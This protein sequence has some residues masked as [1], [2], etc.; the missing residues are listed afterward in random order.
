M[1]AQAIDQHQCRRQ[2]QHDPVAGTFRSHDG[3]RQS[4]AQFTELYT[5]VFASRVCR[6]LLASQKVSEQSC[7]HQPF[8]EYDIQAN[9]MSDEDHQTSEQDSK[10]R[11]LLLKQSPPAAYEPNTRANPVDP[12]EGS[13]RTEQVETE[14]RP[15]EDAWR[16]FCKKHCHLHHASAPSASIKGHF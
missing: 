13:E 6:A 9:E 4:V 1:L 3:S 8:L 14:S 15:K 11:R 16:K 7:V 10:R 12:A 5:A 2:R